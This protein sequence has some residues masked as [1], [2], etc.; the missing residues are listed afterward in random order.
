MQKIKVRLR[1]CEIGSIL[2]TDVVNSKGTSFV[3]KG[4]TVNSFILQKLHD[5]G[6]ESV[7]VYP[8]AV[9]ENKRTGRRYEAVKL[10]YLEVME[11]LKNLLGGLA[12]G[13]GLEP[14]KI[15]RILNCTYKSVNDADCI[16]DL[17]NGLKIYDDYTYCHSANVAFY[18]MLI[19]KWVHLPKPEIM[20]LILS[21]FLHD[22]GKMKIPNE[23]LNKKGRLT[24]EEFE[25]IKEHSIQGYRMIKEDGNIHDAVKDA[26]LSHHERMNGSGYPD[27]IVGTAIN[28]YS[29]IIAIADVYDAMTS[30][31]VYKH[32]TTP[33]EA[34]QMFITTGVCQFDPL[35]SSAFLSNMV[36][37]MPG[38][39][40]QLSDGRIGEIAYVPHNDP[41]NPVICIDSTYINISR[42]KNFQIVNII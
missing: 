5:I 32:R 14:D 39:K 37:H 12:S 3:S 20:D 1:D 16:I 17:L 28:K 27:G 6:I 24:E 19:G 11:A 33:F 22:I 7:Y 25:K 23:I 38:L 4:T 13:K 34:F 41:A 26:V 42:A 35:F 31:R 8:S 10:N 36:A 18:S 15:E 21:G 29:R 2:A 9:M 30:E 40:V